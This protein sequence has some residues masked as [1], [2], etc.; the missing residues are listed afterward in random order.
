MCKAFGIIAIV[1]AKISVVTPEI[2]APSDTVCSS[3]ATYNG[4]QTSIDNARAGDTLLLKIGRYEA[5]PKPYR[6]AICGNCV[7]P[8]TEVNATVGFHIKG[9]PLVIIGE[10]QDSTLLVT[11][12]GYGILLENSFGSY[13]GNL[14][15]TGGIRD[16]DGNATDA[17]FVVK[18]GRV[19][20]ENVRITNNTHR[21]DTLVVG[22]GGIFG[23]EGAELFIFNN[24]IRNNGWD[25]VALYRGATAVI[26]DNVI[27]AGRGAGIG[28]TWDATAIVYRNRISGYWKGIGG[29]GDSRVVVR[30]NVV[31]DNLG[32]GIIATG[33]TYMEVTN[34][35][36]YHNGN[37]GCAVW[38]E[39]ARGIFKNNIIV[40]NG[41]KE[42]WV[43]PGVGIW[44]N[45]SVENF[46]I[47]YNNVWNNT[48]GN[49]EG[50]KDQTDVNGNISQDPLFKDDRSFRL[51]FE[52]PCID[53][54][55]PEIVDLDGTRSDMGGFG[56][57]LA[58]WQYR[59]G[60]TFQK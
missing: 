22:I 40:K 15:V 23:R 58:R 9:K 41:W 2:I 27:E 32:W 6:E 20:L 48:A 3:Q 11:N 33:N 51:K 25:G 43:C 18:N 13:V 53:T 29:F 1:L 49:Y 17:A 35:V 8:L 55:D 31:F 42:Q 44:M 30:N 47:E 4:L 46:P 39:T 14:T 21:I 50:I 16:P 38:K 5:T 24:I 60:K 59:V 37:C 12:G 10:D 7:A 34:N 26:A 54:G 45:T 56:G 57:P 52:S 28:I 36:V 19:T